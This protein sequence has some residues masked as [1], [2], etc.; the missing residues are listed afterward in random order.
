MTVRSCPLI[1]VHTSPPRLK[2]CR[3]HSLYRSVGET[4]L[5]QGRAAKSELTSQLDEISFVTFGDRYYDPGYNPW[6]E[7]STE[8]AA[9]KYSAIVLGHNLG[10]NGPRIRSD[11]AFLTVSEPQPETAVITTF[12]VFNRE[13]PEG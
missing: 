13:F 7:V 12:P 5:E 9:T 1:L 8:T 6:F 2:N 11:V 3:V 10:N 4:P